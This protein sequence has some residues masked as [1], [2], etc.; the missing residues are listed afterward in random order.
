[1]EVLRDHQDFITSCVPTH[2]IL[3]WLLGK[4]LIST[5]DYGRITVDGEVY[6]DG[7]TSN[8]AMFVSLLSTLEEYKDDRSSVYAIFDF[9][10]GKYPSVSVN[11][12]AI[13][14]GQRVKAAI[15][16]DTVLTVALFG[17]DIGFDIRKVQ[18]RYLKKYIYINK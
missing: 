13:Q 3:D 2:G 8:K 7:T 16:P 10:R 11:I 18:V 12:P 5:F 17:K 15:G 9:I 6:T 14:I 4:R 1:M